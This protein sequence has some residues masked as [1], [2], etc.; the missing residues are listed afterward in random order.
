MIKI[1][2]DI[3]GVGCQCYDNAELAKRNALEGFTVTADVAAGCVIVK[4]GGTE[5]KFKEIYLSAKEEIIDG[6]GTDHRKRTGAVKT[7][8]KVRGG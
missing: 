3:T 2:F 1:D 8:G 6:P 7:L 5:R 4:A